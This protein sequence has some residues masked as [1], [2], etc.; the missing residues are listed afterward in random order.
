MPAESFA[1]QMVRH[2]RH[3]SLRR[4][5]KAHGFHWFKVHDRAR[6]PGPYSQGDKTIWFLRIGSMQT[7]VAA[8]SKTWNV[9]D[10]ASRLRAARRALR[11]KAQR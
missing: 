4:S 7:E 8:W 2:S 6:W 11:D 10:I 9:Q 5:R 3:T 1:Q